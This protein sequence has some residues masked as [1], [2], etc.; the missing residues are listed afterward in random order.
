M[1][2]VLIVDDDPA[3]QRL[4]NYSFSQVGFEVA[5]ATTGLAGRRMTQMGGLKMKTCLM[6]VVVV[7][8]LMPS[9]TQASEEKPISMEAIMEEIAAL[10]TL[11]AEQQRQIHELQAALNTGAARS[12]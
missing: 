2:R 3:I 12:A 8:L 10:R 7:A 4:V 11:V 6:I 9:V 5:T 1:E